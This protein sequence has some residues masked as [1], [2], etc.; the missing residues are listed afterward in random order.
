MTTD[1][2]HFFGRQFER[3]I[4]VENHHTKDYPGNEL[5][6]QGKLIEDQ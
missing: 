3:R 4:K 2:A 6:S 5:Y 1:L